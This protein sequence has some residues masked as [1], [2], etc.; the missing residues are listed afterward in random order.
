ML[1]IFTYDS[2]ILSRFEVCC[3][4]IHI[5]ILNIRKFNL[6]GRFYWLFGMSGTLFLD[7]RRGD[8]GA[9]TDF[10]IKTAFIFCDFEAWCCLNIGLS[11]LCRCLFSLGSSLSRC[12]KSA[13][14]A[15]VFNLSISD[16][17]YCGILKTLL[18]GDS[19]PVNLE[20][21]SARDRMF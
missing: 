4:S 11:G 10:T 6:Y 18:G 14:A 9:R 19:I 21:V 8:I 17:S 13:W 1:G 5:H 15:L 12:W 3:I 2:S 7:L 16:F 20:Y